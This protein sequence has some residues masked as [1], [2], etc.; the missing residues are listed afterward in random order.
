M[1][2]APEMWDIYNPIQGLEH[3]P[4]PQEPVTVDPELIEDA[5]RRV[6]EL[7]AMPAAEPEKPVGVLFG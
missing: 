5:K 4:Q 7:E 2:Y 6:E 3:P 1:P